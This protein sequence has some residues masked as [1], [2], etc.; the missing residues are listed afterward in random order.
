MRLSSTQI[1]Q[2]GISAIL[3]QQ[4][5]L[6]QT[7]Q[8]LATGKRIL[9]PSDDPV[10]AVQ[11]LDI[12]QNLTQIDQYNRNG[13]LAQGQL[14]QEESVLT[15]VG[16]LLQRVRDLV[17]QANNASQ[18][19][20]TR[21]AI[22]TEVAARLE[23]L[24][25]L[26]N[27]R[28]ASGEFIFGGFQSATQ[29]F[30][31]Q[32]GGVSYQGDDGQRFLQISSSTQVAVR[33][34][35][36]DVFLA[37]PGGNGVFDLQAAATNS[38]TAVAGSRTV[39]GSFIPDTYTLTYSQPTPTD[40]IT[41]QVTDGTATTVAS[42]TYNAG[43]TINFAGVAIT[44]DGIP[45]NGDSFQVAPAA[46]QDLFG[47]LQNIVDTLNSPGTNPAQLA[48]VNNALAGSLD[49]LDQGLDHVLR[50]RA[51]IGVRLGQV[52]SQRNLND[53][54]NQ[55]L[56]ETLSN[57]QDLDYAEAISRLNL[58]LTAL[59]AAQQ[60]YVKVQGLSLFNFL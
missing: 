17:V 36:R 19:S 9:T 6:Q 23:Q 47:S 42:G 60:T 40:P 15:D 7:Q 58:Q 22:A 1:F 21:Q 56:Q 29:P 49:N 20:E 28:D 3:D 39:T 45:A 10:A 46:S 2:Q 57:V 51:D 27:T 12:S 41:Y 52:E 18:S 25:S 14:A 11:V 32:G 59:E 34:S 48:A 33:D 4:G 50:V 24:Q 43:Q 37:A 13:E 54:F 55:Q 5:K 38:G 16:D 26:A 30:V 53:N 8:Q 31:N 44:F 35:G